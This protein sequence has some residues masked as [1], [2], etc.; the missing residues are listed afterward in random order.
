MK[1]LNRAFF[2]SLFMVAV[3]MFGSCETKAKP[4]P[5]A[6]SP[7]ANLPDTNQP[8][9]QKD[10]VE[11]RLAKLGFHVFAEPQDLPAFEVPSLKGRVK[12][13]AADS[14]AAPATLSPESLKG[15]V[16]LLNFW[17]TWCPPCKGEMPSIEKLQS[18]MKGTSFRIAAVSVGEKEKTVADFI[19]A[20]GYTFPVYLD[21]NGALGQI[22]ASQGIPTTYIVDKTGKVIAGTVGAR[23]YDDPEVISILKELAAR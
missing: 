18:A 7:A 21:G 3:L 9:A 2:M 20:Q 8:S 22:F 19:A 10:S 13:D 17:A 6:S 5:A 12:G 4:G 11:T 23:E 1:T 14:S 16:T 15:T